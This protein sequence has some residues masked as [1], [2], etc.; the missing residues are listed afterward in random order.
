M[1]TT[2][3]NQGIRI[4]QSTDDPDVVDDLTKAVS[5]LEKRVVMVFNNSSD[6]SARVATP[7]E[8]MLSYLKDTDLFYKHDGSAWVALLPV[9]PTFTSGT[10]VPSNAS[11]VDGDIFF[12]V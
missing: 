11:G 9:I 3:A 5:D 2:T 4:P 1:A 12:K 6:R 7:T 8:G 10:A